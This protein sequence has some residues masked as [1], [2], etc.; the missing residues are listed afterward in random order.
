MAVEAGRRQPA[1]DLERSTRS[2][3]S[4][5]PPTI[6]YGTDVYRYDAATGMLTLTHNSYDDINAI[7]FWPGDPRVMYVGLEVESDVR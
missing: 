5:L 3:F 1:S 6:V 4:S 7:A 2:T